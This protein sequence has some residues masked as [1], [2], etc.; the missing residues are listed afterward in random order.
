MTEKEFKSIMDYVSIAL[1]RAE[2]VG[3]QS[4]IRLI[5]AEAR[6]LRNLSK[7]P[8]SSGR[9]KLSDIPVGTFEK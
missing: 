5:G 4:A 7:R 8:K 9:V 1:E 6:R 2:G 3:V